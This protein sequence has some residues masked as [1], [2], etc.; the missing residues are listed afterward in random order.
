M[1]GKLL[2]LIF[3]GEQGFGRRRR[4][5][6]GRSP[7]LRDSVWSIELRYGQH[8]RSHVLG[9]A[10]SLQASSARNFADTSSFPVSG[11][12]RRRKS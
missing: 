3:A 8:Q 11:R 7:P 1:D 4:S 9:A 10:D 12:E 6:A 5:F 2:R